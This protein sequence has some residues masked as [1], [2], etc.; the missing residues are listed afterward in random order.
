MAETESTLQKPPLPESASDAAS[1][2]ESGH[3]SIA[4]SE[5]ALAALMGPDSGSPETVT[6]KPAAEVPSTVALLSSV[7][8]QQVPEKVTPAPAP[9][10]PPVENVGSTLALIAAIKENRAELLRSEASA[11]PAVAPPHPP[12]TQPPAPVK[13]KQQVVAPQKTERP[14]AVKITPPVVK[15]T[16]PAVRVTP[17][18]KA[19]PQPTVA[20]IPR[21]RSTVFPANVPPPAPVPAWDVPGQ[22]EAPS[23]MTLVDKIPGGKNSLLIAGA[24]IAIAGISVGLV[25]RSH[26]PAKPQVVAAAVQP[27]APAATQAS[28]F[29][30]Q[31]QVEPQS[32]GSINVRWNPQ[33]TLI[34]QAREGR[35]VITES[36]Q[37]PRTIAVALEQLKFGHLTYQP[38]SE[39]V[40]LR[41][42]VVDQSGSTAEESVLALGPVGGNKTQQTP[43]GQTPAPQTTQEAAVQ[44][45]SQAAPPQTGRAAVREFTPPS[46]RRIPEQRAIVDAPPALP[47]AAVPVPLIGALT[48]GTIAPPPPTPAAQ[49][50]QVASSLQA[51]N[52]IKKVTPLYPPLA[53]SAHVQGSVRFTALIGMDG[54]IR[55]L[56]VTSGPPLL[57]QPA[58]DAVKQWVYRPTLLNGKPIEVV[59]QIEVNFTL[60]Q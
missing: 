7:Q 19:A 18:A 2:V 40:E 41:L 57:R 28:N 35:L 23:V 29:P 36:N 4:L 43:S 34:V 38:Q 45:A 1:G 37:K 20:P 25:L 12:P 22:S 59:T 46:A 24:V 3:V 48:P 39:R 30:L 54:A 50:I 27:V 11:K 9:A 49:P 32:N 58:I 53:K 13:T 33:S 42:E 5:E 10:T 31:L 21:A 51:A 14:P 8:E 17:P 47:N 60:N 56:E 44:P 15:I 6:P 52:L 55:N 26:R 16:P